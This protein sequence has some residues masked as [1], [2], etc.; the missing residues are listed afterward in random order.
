MSR[1]QFDHSKKNNGGDALD[2]FLEKCQGQVSLKMKGLIQIYTGNGKGKTTAAL[3]LALRAAGAG[4][5]V[6]IGQFIKS[7]IY[8]EIRALRKLKSHITIEQYG[9]GCLIK[10]RPKRKDIELAK[11]GLAKIK[12]ILSRRA[13]DVV[14]LDEINIA[15]H[16]KLLDLKDVTDIIK[17]KLKNIELVFTGRYAHPKIIKSADMV[18]EMKEIK[19]YFKKGIKARRGIEY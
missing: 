11:K 4:L 16:L 14:I 13:Y 10:G 15:L 12:K 3:G 6:Y 1:V 8:N 9:R 18:T 5:K 19:H 7:G 17:S 2:I